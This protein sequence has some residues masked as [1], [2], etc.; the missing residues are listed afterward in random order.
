MLELNNKEMIIRYSAI[1]F[2]LGMVLTIT[3]YAL[4]LHV[5]ETPFS[6]RALVQ[7]HGDLPILF[8]LDPLAFPALL[9][10]AWIANWRFKQLHTLSEKIGQ[11][12]DK[13]VEI[14]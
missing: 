12:T 11:E 9:F 2:V 6:F 10:G 1:G 8:L 14:K 7:L 4:L 5:L 13:N 3:Q